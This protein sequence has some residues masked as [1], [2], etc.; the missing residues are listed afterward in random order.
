V[1]V[2]PEKNM[3][4]VVLAAGD[5]GRLHP[6][7]ADTPKP[8]LP[9]RG[10]PI[11]RHVLASLRAGGI[12]DVAIVVG[13]RGDQ[14][15]D[16]LA[17]S[18]PPGLHIRFIENEAWASGNARSLWAVHDAVRAPFIL[19]MADHLLDPAIVRALIGDAGDR[20]RLAIDR[21]PAA[22]PR[23][24]DA[25]R[26]LVEGTLVVDLGKEIEPWNALD[27]GAFWC[28]ARV[29]DLL[30]PETRDGELAAVFARLARS[31]DLDA[32][33]VTGRCW[34]DID[35]EDDLRR[36]DELLGAHGRLA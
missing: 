11:I 20:C 18:A 16:A 2:T 4:A 19:K 8:L 13:Y 32:V 21:V 24:I 30:T 10:Q 9:L 28:T 33:D 23:A 26:A 27:T 35:T 1:N 17:A 15:R 36:A 22:D 3:E 5:G 6:R 12:D 31:G 7:T 14:V 25:T 34:I 29:F